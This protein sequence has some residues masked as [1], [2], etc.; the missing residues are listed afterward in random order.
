MSPKS[1]FS[2]MKDLPKT[3]LLAP[4]S[5]MCAGC[6]GLEAVREIYDVLGGKT[7]FV[8]AAGCM[9][10][11]SVY[12]YTPFRGSWLY[13]AM[14]S[15]PAGAQGIRDALDILK[16]H[17]RIGEDE[18]LDVVVLT[19]D[20][21]AYGMGL[22]STSGAIDRD[23]DFLYVIYDNE[24]YGN[25]GQ[26]TSAATPHGARTATAT[27]GIGVAG[28]KK[29][30]FSILAAHEPAYVATVIGAEPLD[31][32]RKVERAKTMSG[33]RFLIALSPCPTGWGFDPQ[34]S[35]EIG[36]LAV[37]SGAWPLKEY[38]DGRL[39]HNR[40]P[41]PLVPVEEYLKRQGRF[42]HLFEPRKDE[43]TLMDIQAQID[44]YWAGVMDHDGA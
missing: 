40:V 22:S 33:P 17:D 37:K 2:G 8:N 42:R 29:D 23:L 10:L 12:P 3:H 39:V 20:G 11:M 38:V 9:T 27:S 28:R 43:F 5:A 31:L 41:K 6:G 13:T 14:A 26:Q 21:S 36:K 19:G 34:L 25:T 18:D 24:G 15:A 7:V 32:A 44:A 1:Q 4:G 30:L 16:S 35:V